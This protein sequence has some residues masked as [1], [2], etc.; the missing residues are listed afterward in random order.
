MNATS[1]TPTA[2]VWT[3]GNQGTVPLGGGLARLRAWFERRRLMR[4][5][6]GQLSSLSDHQLYDIG[7]E[8]GDIREVAHALV[9]RSAR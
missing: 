8:R 1:M 5:T 3:G 6:V 2:G 9:T 4:T 7:V